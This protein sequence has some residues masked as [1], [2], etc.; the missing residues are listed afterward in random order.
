LLKE[1]TLD[2]GLDDE[3]F[4]LQKKQA[5]RLM[6]FVVGVLVALFL[7]TLYFLLSDD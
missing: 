5:E 3:V 2:D 7:F 6:K 4:D 1:F